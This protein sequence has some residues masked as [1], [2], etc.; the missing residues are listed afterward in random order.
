MNDLPEKT[1][2][3]V[4][5]IPA[6]ERV[7]YVTDVLALY[8]NA[9]WLEESDD[10]EFIQPMLMNSFAVAGAF[11]PEEDGGR[12]IGMMRALSDGVSD[13]YLLD[14]V[15]LTGYRGQGTA[16]RILEM[17]T[18]HLKSLGIDWIVCVSVPGVEHLYLRSGHRM[19]HHVPIRF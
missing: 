15:V 13:A 4:R 19:E 6:L 11:S 5:I 9:G 2:I 7:R 8:R 10:T 16:S 3:E 18:S 1:G 12:L 14:M 17:L